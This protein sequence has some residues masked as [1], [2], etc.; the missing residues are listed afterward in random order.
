[1][2]IKEVEL[3]FSS[4]PEKF[5]GF[6]IVHI[7]D[8]H[9]DGWRGDTDRISKIVSRINSL[10]ADVICFTGDLVSVSYSETEP[11]ENI[12]N[13]FAMPVYSVLG[14]HDYFP[15]SRLSDAERLLQI[16]SL[17]NKEKEFG[18]NLLLNESVEISREGEKIVIAGVEN[19]SC[20]AHNVIHRG[21]LKRTLEGHENDFVILLSHDP[22]HWRMEVL[23]DSGVQLTLS[24]HTHAMQFRCFGWTPSKYIYPECD[25]LYEEGTQKLYVNIGLG[26]TFPARFGAT[27]EIT[28]ITLHKQ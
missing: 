25:G 6:R 18:W 13:G 9:L 4:L 17:K 19:Q 1:M 16:D 22:S 14:N 8:L 28:V 24:G 20:G 10:N 5:D 27:P 15:Y 21:D 7:S 23:P 3:S 2:E 26:G 12:L 11:V